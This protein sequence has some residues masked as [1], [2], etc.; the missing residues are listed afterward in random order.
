MRD[1]MSFLASPGIKVR[2]KGVMGWKS[3]NVVVSDGER[4]PAL[5]T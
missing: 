3:M 5:I 1:F 2:Q 4:G